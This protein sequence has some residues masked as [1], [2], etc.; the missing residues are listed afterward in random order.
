M[1][2][3]LKKKIKIKYYNNKK[4]IYCIKREKYYLF[5]YE[6]HLRQLL[7]FYLILIKGFSI[8]NIRV[9]NNF[10]YTYSLFKYDI[11]VMYNKRPYIIIECKSPR[12]T[13]VKENID[14]L[15]K[16]GSILNVE[17]YCLTNKNDSFIFSIK[18]NKLFFF[19]DLPYNSN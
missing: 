18:N 13:I 3:C 7:I 4:Y 1:I 2:S 5:S 6:E 9:E 16:Y 15:I 11:L 10:F 17:Y 14:Q 8:I 12:K 19:K